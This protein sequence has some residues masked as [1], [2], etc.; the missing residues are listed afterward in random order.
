[1][2]DSNTT[3]HGAERNTDER[4]GQSK[5]DT[6]TESNTGALI[7]T[8]K[9]DEGSRTGGGGVLGGGDISTGEGGGVLGGGDNVISTGEGGEV[10]GCGDNVIST[11][12]GG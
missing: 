2:L 9:S 1:V 8:R 11:G 10:L 7:I 3:E 12:E 5:R 6:N 4:R